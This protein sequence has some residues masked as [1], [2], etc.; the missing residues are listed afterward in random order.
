VFFDKTHVIVVFGAAF[1]Q[2][3]AVF[4]VDHFKVEVG[5]DDLWDGDVKLILGYTDLVVLTEFG[6]IEMGSHEIAH[7]GRLPSCA[8]N[9]ACVRSRY[10]GA[11]PVS[12]S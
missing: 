7:G 4:E 12:R 6:K 9:R 2:I 3:I 1:D 5:G 8:A 10:V 11:L